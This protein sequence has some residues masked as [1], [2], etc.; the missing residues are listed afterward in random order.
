MI[1]RD[2]EYEEY[3]RKLE[4]I[5]RSFERELE[6]V[7]IKSPII[8]IMDLIIKNIIISINLIR[9]LSI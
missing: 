2:T 6:S 4:E 1:L 8:I 3:L 7:I 5:M 9:S